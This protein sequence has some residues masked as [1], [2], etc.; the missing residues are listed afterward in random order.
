M[1]LLGYNIERIKKKNALHPDFKR[2]TEYAFEIDGQEFYHFKNYLDMPA[3]RFQKMNEFI[4]EV[5]MRITRDDLAEYLSICKE[6]INK[7]KMTDLIGIIQGIEY[8]LDQF[9]ETDTYYRL[10]SC[11]FFTLDEDITDYDYDLNE[12]KI[13]LFKSQPIDSFFLNYPMSEYLPQMDISKEDLQTFL[14]MSKVSNEYLRKI[15]SEYTKEQD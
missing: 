7:G 15:K 8:R 2:L 5:E 1:K 13:A 10:F 14:K 6:A 3:R 9:I 4:A 12:T 11:A